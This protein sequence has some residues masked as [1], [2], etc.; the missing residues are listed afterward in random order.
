MKIMI[1]IP[2]LSVS[3]LQSNSIIGAKTKR[4][5]WLNQLDFT[6][7]MISVFFVFSALGEN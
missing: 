3:E 5:S 2:D 7:A 6:K 1:Y 4:I